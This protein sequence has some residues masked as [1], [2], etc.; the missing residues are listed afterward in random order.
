MAQATYLEAIRQGLWRDV[1]FGLVLAAS[2]TLHAQK[3]AEVD[4]TRQVHAV[5]EQSILPPE[6]EGVQATFS[7]GDG[8]ILPAGERKR[9]ELHVI[10]L[11]PLSP[12]LG[13]EVEAEITLK[14]VAKAPI[15]I[16]WETDPN[17]AQRPTE[18]TRYEY[19][20][21]WFWI[22]IR[23]RGGADRF[24]KSLSNPLYSSPER[25]QSTL[26]LEPGQ[27]V[28]MRLKFRLEI[29]EKISTAK[30]EPGPAE[31]KIEWRQGN[32]TWERKG[33]DGKTGYST[34]DSFYE[35]KMDPV[36]IFLVSPAEGLAHENPR[37]PK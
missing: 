33:C 32:Y 16:P 28:A 19:E 13:S 6:C 35:Q 23:D 18:A 15:E 3:V 9:L 29:D 12:N 27:W 36:S 17:A 30:L 31:L 34:Y 14:N 26:K 25:P 11:S 24:L 10:S 4:L 8:Y 2:L 20:A 21:A 22:R 7:H 1:A 5:A 37:S